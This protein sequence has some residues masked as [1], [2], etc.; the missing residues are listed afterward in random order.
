MMTAP[1]TPFPV[2]REKVIRKSIKKYFPLGAIMSQGKNN[3]ITVH[4]VNENAFASLWSF[5][6]EVMVADGELPRSTKEA[7]ALLVSSKNECPMCC[8]AHRMM[9]TAAKRAEKNSDSKLNEEERA[10]KE[11]MYMLS[12][13]YAEVL[14]LDTL[15]FRVK[16][17]PALGDGGDSSSH[18]SSNRTAITQR[19]ISQDFSLLTDATKAEI[20]LIVVL[21]FHVNRIISALLG[22]QMSKAMFSVP[23]VAAKRIEAPKVIQVV[24]KLMAPFM[25][26]RMK[27]K[28]APGITS[29]LFPDGGSSLLK[30]GMPKHLMGA[31]MAGE[32]RSNALER[33]VFWS[34]TYEKYLIQE[35]LVS[36]EAVELLDNPARAPPEGLKPSKVSHWATTVMRKL[37]RA[38]LRN[39]EKAQEI[40]NVLCLVSYSPQSV[41]HSTSWLSMVKSLGEDQARTIVIWW[42]LRESIKRAQGLR[43]FESQCC[44]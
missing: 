6:A 18:C 30:A 8:S 33:L 32:E 36:E 19:E 15:N 24:S 4:S 10:R 42:S 38:S 13:D 43:K 23:E 34:K 5:M 2:A 25:A 37:I 44:I 11:E 27:A 7:I 1:V 31:S 16:K 12:L 41:Y 17:Q 9:G 21:F 29:P 14:I 39:D 3:P 22:E 26:G 40:A 28:R 20:S 35:G